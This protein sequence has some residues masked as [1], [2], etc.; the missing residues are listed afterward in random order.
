M[1]LLI[2][3]NLNNDSYYYKINHGTYKDYRVGDRNQYDHEIILIIENIYLEQYKISK[4]SK[5]KRMVL[6]KIISFLQK[7]NK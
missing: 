6:T 1:K 3:H 5:L 2:Y 7:I 4:F